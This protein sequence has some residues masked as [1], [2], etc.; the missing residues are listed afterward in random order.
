MAGGPGTGDGPHG[1]A[2]FEAANK[3]RGS[4]ESAEYKHLVL[5]LLFLKYISDAFDQRRDAL[6]AELSEPGSGAYI[7]DAD[8]RADALEDRDEYVA[9]NVF[10]VPESARWPALLAAA[11]QPDVARGIDDALSAIEQENPGLRNV[12]PRVYARAPLSAELMGSLVETIAKI[13]FGKDPKE[14]RDVLG[15]VYELLEPPG[16][17]GRLREAR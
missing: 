13:G 1:A 17:A 4:V 5:G 12:L 7:E 15:R 3:L 16:S 10:W 8:A 14:A 6:E 2:L 9:E 11:S